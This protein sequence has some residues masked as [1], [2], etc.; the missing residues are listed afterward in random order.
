MTLRVVAIVA[1][2]LVLLE[3][4][5]LSLLFDVQPFR[6]RADGLRWIGWAGVLGPLAIVAGT[7]W[8]LLA[9][10]DAAPNLSRP[11]RPSGPRFAWMAAHVVSY[12]AL[13]GLSAG[14]EAGRTAPAAWM[15]CAVT[16]A[17]TAI[18]AWIPPGDLWAQVRRGPG[19]VLAVVG[20]A[21]GAFGLAALSGSAWPLLVEM[22]LTG[23][24]AV[25]ISWG[26]QPLLL[27]DR[28]LLGLGDFLV[29]VNAACSGME[30]V[31][32]MIVF[33]G[34]YIAL[35]RGRLRLPAA[36][37]ALPIAV[38]AVLA[39]NVFRIALLVSIGGHGHPDVA[40]GGFHSKA[41]W[42]L[43]SAIALG[44]VAVTGRVF[45][46]PSAG[47]A[48]AA[49]VPARAGSA[50]VEG[51]RS[52]GVAAAPFIVPLLVIIGASML[53]GLFVAD[54]PTGHPL[55][56]LAGLAATGWGVARAPSG[57]GGRPRWLESGT[58]G[59]LVYALWMA[60]LAEPDLARTH[61]LA[62]ELETTPGWIALKVVGSVVVVPIAEE[63][64]FRG[65]LLRRV[66][67]A[68]FSRLD[69]RALG[70]WCVRRGAPDATWGLLVSSLVFGFLHQ[71][72]VA[73]VGAGLL[74]G[75]LYLRTGRLIDA[76]LAHA[77]TNAII[78]ANVVLQGAWW[79]WV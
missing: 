57:V 9:R 6:A 29:E 41:G 63:L 49:P 52:E 70:V 46:A 30:G 75:G 23:A 15:G 16:T 74:Y 5:V 43:F 64:A 26:E 47:E 19:R 42:V 22:T 4:L 53:T 48:T 69:P 11:W 37:I 79:L 35:D 44:A 7:S 50:A 55:V 8:L 21:V 24:A 51:G 71:D 62:A 17:A 38:A 3:Y 39:A 76:I 58:L 13:L 20:L 56:V 77:V 61:R 73:G 66:A 54:A 31:G 59:V 25:L 28:Q 10:R 12:G 2:A 45:A 78:A 36:W 32:L 67:S 68:G 14:L 27:P 60:A 18:A 33:L 40:L 1:P 34:A 72:V 65:F